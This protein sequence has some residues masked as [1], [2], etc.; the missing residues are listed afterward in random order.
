MSVMQPLRDEHAELLPQIETIRRVADVVG[1]TSAPR[2]ASR[3]PAC[4]SSSRPT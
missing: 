4:T 3:S 2:C 1:L